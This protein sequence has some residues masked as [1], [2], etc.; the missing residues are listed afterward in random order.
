VP[1]DVGVLFFL[2]APWSKSKRP[3]CMAV[4]AGSG[5]DVPPR[6]GGHCAAGYG[7]LGHREEA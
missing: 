2:D 1:V 3:R 4:C 7:L 5:F 6:S